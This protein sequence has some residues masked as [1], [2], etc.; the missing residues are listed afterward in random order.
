MSDISCLVFNGNNQNTAMSTLIS[1]KKQN[2]VAS[3]LV[4]GEKTE[5]MLELEK[6][7]G[8]FLGGIGYALKKIGLGFL[9]S[10]EDIW[11]FTAGGLAK[12]FGADDWA[13]QQF[14]NDWVNYG[15]ADEWYNPSDGWQ[16]VGDVAGGIGTSIPA[17]ATVAAAAAIAFF[18]GGTLT[19]LAAGL[20]AGTVAG[21]GAAGNATKEAYRQ[22]GELGG[23][24]FGYGAL[25][26]VT[27]GSVEGLSSAI[28][29][30]TGAVVKGITKSFGKEIAESATRQTL[31]KAIV[32][33]FIGEAFE[34]GLSEMLNPVWAR[35]TYDPN[36]KNATFQEIG[37]AA[38]VGGL[39]GAIMGGT[40]VSVRNTLSIARGNTIATEGKTDNVL[41]MS[42]QLSTYEQANKTGLESFELV[43]NVYNE[44]QASLK[45]TNGKISSIKQKMLLGVLEKA[46]TNAVFSPIVARSAENI[47]NNAETI[48]EKITAYGLTD[49]DGNAI[50]FT[51]EQ[52]LNGIDI[53]N[54]KSYSKA[55][56]TNDILRSLAVADATGQI[57]M[58]T[59]KSKEATLM[60]QK[61]SSQADLNRFVETATESELK[62]TGE[63]LGIDNW[64][65]ITNAEFQ[66]KITEFVKNGGIESYKKERLIIKDAE[67]IGVDT[68]K[69]LPKRLN[70]KE[71]GI[72]RYQQGDT[73][74]AVI[75]SGDDY[76][77][78]DYKSKRLTNPLTLQEVNKVLREL[79]TQEQVLA[80]KVKQELEQEAERR[81]QVAEID[82]YARE[83]IAD[84]NKLN[85]PNQSMIRAVIRQGRAAGIAES[86]ILSYARVSAHSGINI[87]FNK[88]MCIVGKDTQT[89]ENVYSDGYCDPQNNRIVINPE[90]KRT[91]EALL[92]HELDHAIRKTED[93]HIIL[94][95]GVKNMSQSDK[96][97]IIN[98]YRNAG[99][100]G[101]IELMEELSAHYAEGILTNKNI[102]ERLCESKPTLKE[103]ILNF[104]KKSSKTYYDDIKLSK[105]A[106]SL[107][108]RY[109]KLFDDFSLGENKKGQRI[110]GNQG[111]NA[112]Y[113]VADND[114]QADSRFAL[115]DIDYYTEKQ[116][117]NY[118]WI[119][120]NEVLTKN[121]WN[122]FNH[123]FTQAK[124]KHL[125]FN[126]TINGEFIIPVN[127]E[128]GEQFGIDNV[129]VYAK[130]TT[131]N[132][133]ITKIIKIDL[134]DE[135]SIDYVRRYIYEREININNTQ[136]NFAQDY[137]GEELIREVRQRDFP[138]YQ[139]YKD[140]KRAQR[141][142]VDGS[143]D[144]ESNKSNQQR[145]GD[146][147]SSKNNVRYAL[148]AEQENALIKRG[149][150][151]DDLLN[152][153]DLSDEI[154]SVGGTITNTAKAVLYHATTAENAKKILQS[155]KMYGKEPNIYFST[156]SDGVI[157]GYG[158]TV[159]QAE[160]PLEKLKANDLFDDELHLTIE[161]K[162]YQMT[163]IRYALSETDSTGKKLSV[164]QRKFFKDSKVV[165]EKGNLLVVYHN[166]NNN[167]TIFDKNY[168]GTGLSEG[169]LGNL[170]EGFYFTDS[171]EFYSHGHKMSVYLDIKKP[172]YLG[173]KDNYQQWVNLIQN[174]HINYDKS[175]DL[176][177]SVSTIRALGQATGFSGENLIKTFTKLL[178][179][180]NFDGIIEVGGYSTDFVVF[181]P[182]Q[183][184]E[185]SNVNPTT[186]SDIRFALP[187][188]DNSGK[189][190]SKQQI[191]YFKD[192]KIK[193]EQGR[194]IVAYHGTNSKFFTFRNKSSVNGRSQG[195]GF[196]FSANNE[197]ATEYGDRVITAYLNI[198]NPF[199]LHE[200]RTIQSEL[201]HRGYDIKELTGKYGI[202]L[203]EFGGISWGKDEKTLLTKM[204]Y[205]GVI[206]VWGEEDA[207]S[208]NAEDRTIIVAYKPSQ[209]KEITNTTPTKDSDIRFALQE[210]Q[211]SRRGRFSKGQRAKFAAN[212][213][214]FKIYSRTDAV[215]VINSILE[216]RLVFDDKFGRLSGKNKAE[217]IDFLFNKLNST[218]PAYQGT[219]AL[220]IADYIIENTLM[221]DIYEVDKS[222]VMSVLSILRSYMH[223]INLSGIQ[224]E[225][226]YK[227]GKKSGINML[228]GNNNATQTPD[229]I[230]QELAEY[231]IIIESINEADIFFE[232]LDKYENARNEVNKKVDTIKLKTFGSEAELKQLR[233]Q[234]AKDILLAYDEKGTQSKYG[235]LVEKYTSKITELRK[236]VKE[237][238]K[239]N[240]FV[241]NIIDTAQYLRDIANKRS[242][243]GAEVFNAPEL[244]SWLK[245]LG[246]LKYRSDIRKASARAVLLNYGKFYNTS[247]TLLYDED[248]NLNY[249]DN[250]VID[251]INLIKKNETSTAPLSLEE[252]QAAQVILASAKHLFA[253]YDQMILEGK[254]VS[255]T[256]TA[257][258]G[259]AILKRSKNR[260]GKSFFNEVYGI[261]NKIIEPR[262][263]IKSFENFDPNG[264]LTRVYKQI[265]DGETA[266]GLMYIDLVNDFDNF[267]KQN[268][269]YKKRL[270]SEYIKV[271]NAELTIGQ[272]V[273][274]YELSKR[275]QAKAGLYESGFSYLDKKG[276]KKSVKIA[277]K[278]IQELYET[279]TTTDK[280][281]IAIVEEFFN[282]KSK[283]VKTDADLQI[284][285]Y[286][287]AQDDF[288]FPIKRDSGTIAKNVTDARNIM[289]DWANVY[290][291]SFN[292]DVKSGSKNKLFITDVYNIVSKHAKQLSTYVNLTVPLKNFSQLYV[293]NVGS[294]TDVQT[295]KN[296]ISEQVWDGADK[297][298]TKLFADIQGNATSNSF[299]EKLRGAYAKYQLGAN[300]KVIVS[301]VTSYPTAGVILD[302]DTMAKGAVMKTDY[303]ALDEYCPYAKV[304][305]YEKGVVRAESVIDKVG[306]V[307]D[308]LTKPIQW[309][310]R[311]TIGKLWNAC[312]LQV[313]K[314]NGLKVG[315][316]ENMQAAGVLLEEVV[317]L[318]QP[319]YTNT[320]R[321]ELM[322]SE[323]DIVRSFTM[324]TSVPLKQLSR[325]VESV[326]EFNV[327][328]QM[329]K[330]S[331]AS[332]EV[333]AR[334]KVAKRKLGRTLAAITV[335]N[336]MYVLV[337]QFFKW[338]YNKDR[339]DKD[340]NEMGIA[341]DMFNDFVST[342]IGMLP[343][344]KDIYNFF[345]ND[346]EF[347]NFAYETI[348]SVLSSSK[349]LFELSTKAVNGQITDK[350]DYMRPFRNALY[351]MG[352]ISG[353][354]TRNINNLI[355]GL[356]KRFDPATAYKYNS[357]FYNAKYSHDIKEALEKGDYKLADTIMGLML[358][359]DKA[360][361]LNTT[362]RQKLIEL[363]EKEYVVL[364]KSFNNSVKHNGETINFNKEQIT[365]FKQVYKQANRQVEK[366]I[367]SNSFKGLS[368]EKQAKAIKQLY[369]AYYD[370]ALSETLGVEIDN[371]LLELAKYIDIATLSAVYAGMSEIDSD[372]DRQGN[373]ITGSKKSKLI[374][375]LRMQNLKD[376]QMLLILA[377]QGYKVQDK[378]YKGLSAQQANKLLLKYI[379]GL[380]STTQAEKAKLA[381][382]CGFA[383]KNGKILIGSV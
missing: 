99:R 373:T 55:L 200:K 69:R 85:A 79:N 33:G 221:E 355:S 359:E 78:Y 90:T 133:T 293:K 172:Y 135:T 371:K 26:G 19:P 123:K 332:T 141:G 261:F 283:Q 126:K 52:I 262:V 357:M 196:Y 30:G 376:E 327:L 268:K 4:A 143:K 184:K 63:K 280:E 315:T 137:F 166:S 258:N 18:S 167:F 127:N 334:Y 147:S 155:G 377:Y 74:L 103:K 142:R 170:G 43:Q 49:S 82:N 242:Y 41:K 189:Q 336:L 368:D 106:K 37:Y 158:N 329:V 313:Q 50:T 157:L 207:I 86:D 266:S 105:E 298:L 130:G 150:K 365:K 347:T 228:W 31:G 330:S 248:P 362:A 84:Y 367:E 374:K 358:N 233:Q 279:F 75:K 32:K 225:I 181:E 251:A 113:R 117:N 46:N 351:S 230:A 67:N 51:T 256:E 265:T 23:K 162:P 102:L 375:Y 240:R 245:E 379:L 17:M 378:E 59:A 124:T 312:Q 164:N 346:Y 213:T 68:A 156:R 183:I 302:I 97:A 175:I 350:S 109:K 169:R 322:R 8:G 29:A 353:I 295:I 208:T 259:I 27:E 255:I 177:K 210:D 88:E 40:D 205:D 307:G 276:A 296:V 238:N 380:K 193:D 70:I 112:A 356:T 22:T 316:T 24:E 12:L 337:G 139:E 272:A 257:S 222:E 91:H 348:E 277:D 241:N 121:Q 57:V 305:N 73:Q 243:V 48:A 343:V 95:Q 61:L 246:K 111:N 284:L 151:G 202:E 209:I 179:Q 20:I 201:E 132:P 66:E 185:T 264:I 171:S 194:L 36:A 53:N 3:Q 191:N 144:I 309:T 364:P 178:K 349:E 344:V 303:K 110:G 165:D 159:I 180:Q 92:L 301:Q 219:V 335:A 370:K 71:D 304:R 381:K 153:A 115:Q 138:S 1:N 77:I 299:I 308:I 244:T 10:I 107:Y 98:R 352:Q 237:A 281:F 215:E 9:S 45:N 214:K 161:V 116:Y 331:N 211:D 2:S 168:T 89:G 148:S 11:D 197:F 149:V 341:Q 108:K 253:N 187:T 62:A 234:I 314:D 218:E 282:V 160:I 363:Y 204:G 229:T 128:V 163:N 236:Q 383:V 273:S 271:G 249:I 80:D 38:L 120:T 360:G 326:G 136:G 290:N 338:L 65:G 297:Y 263:V 125:T 76:Q 16:F 239:K 122:D 324:F 83:N 250:N 318:T 104:F 300:L 220:K 231:G 5:S 247:N 176:S 340:G 173:V 145:R 188:E 190:L 140:N 366:M 118:G 39:S 286:T 199:Y 274:L 94:E 96:D 54:T 321:S 182:N 294:K 311:L 58:N 72:T 192:S 224:G 154:L 275:E 131:T 270:V 267:F 292:K 291:F 174:S 47:I 56:K 372:K 34:E 7:N 81:K 119:R 287:N 325:L 289:S 339:K 44:L 6:N 223:N 134:F 342:N 28:G 146:N 328:R 42:E 114:I 216:D 320:E 25:V 254:K 203:N 227:F 206:S 319:N 100:G 13:E 232:I 14:A 64:Q 35:L 212:N 306:K 235:K 310:D 317:R 285:G 198:K 129:L 226:Q 217:I 369:D 345:V 382:K 15:H 260:V 269:N 278:N 323:S 93:G 21:V 87:V 252:L 195:D 101:T 60:G 288:Y 333:A 186:D 354:P 152:A 361:E